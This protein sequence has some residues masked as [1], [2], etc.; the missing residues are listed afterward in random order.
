MEVEKLE[1][2]GTKFTNVLSKEY[3]KLLDNYCRKASYRR[4]PKED[5]TYMFYTDVPDS[6]DQIITKVIEDNLN[7]KIENIYSFVRINT[8]LHD[9]GFRIH[10]DSKVFNKQPTLAC[11]FYLN[12]SDISGTAFFEHPKHGKEASDDNHWVFTEDD[13]NWSIHNKVYEQ[14]NSMIVYNSR[15]FHGRFPWVSYGKTKRDG[16]IVLVK[17]MREIK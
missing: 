13:G 4:L 11:V 16:R 17:F 8:S 2:I 14:K 9:I 5:N 12:D 1:G 7:T 10:A 6:V 3:F 15:L